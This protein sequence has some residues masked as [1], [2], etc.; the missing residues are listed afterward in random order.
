MVRRIL[1][2]LTLALIA[3]CASA[4]EKFV[5]EKIEVRN[6]HRVS[7]GMIVAE[8]ALREGSAYSEDDVRAGVARLNHLPFLLSAD[9]AIEKGTDDGRRVLVINVIEMKRTSF[10]V[11]ARGLS[12]DPTHQTIDYDFD[13]PGESND[14]LAVRWMAGDRGMLHFASAVRRGRQSFLRRYTAWEIGYSRYGLFG[15]GAFATF[16]LRTP[17]DSVNEGRFSPQI[18][19]GFPLTPSQTLTVEAHDTSFVRDTLTLFGTRLNQ[20]DAERII[21]LAWTYDTT[22]QPFAPARG[23]FVRIAPVHSMSDRAAFH[24]I[25]RS[26]SFAA[27]AEH[28]NTNGVD[29][30]AEHYWELAEASSL[31][32][33]LEAGWATIEDR[34]HPPSSLTKSDRRPTY[35]IAK[36]GY[37]RDIGKSRMSR[38]EL[39]ARFRM[40]QQGID[41]LPGREHAIEASASW[42][43]RSVWGTFRLGFGYEWM[44]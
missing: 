36:V 9:F 32:A 29:F 6:A 10:L 3:L 23:T 35:E 12:G 41:G 16:N 25:P 8:T 17:V 30:A 24:S 4:Q 14:A 33:G 43:R 21:T 1:T 13:R 27:Y 20:L 37:L 26:T 28:L 7:A 39:E 5:I 42:M 40:D 18:E 11:D 22:D 38:L 15:T 2:G 19:V 31:S 34:I 44:H